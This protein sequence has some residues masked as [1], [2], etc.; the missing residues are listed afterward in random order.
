MEK[1][2]SYADFQ[3][4]KSVA[5]AC[6]PFMMKRDKIKRQIEALYVDYKREDDKIKVLEAGI[7][8]FIGFPVEQLV[9][10]V[11]ESGI[12]GKGQPIKTTKYIPTEIVSYDEKAK[13]Y[14]INIPDAEEPAV[15]PVDENTAEA[16]E[17][18]IF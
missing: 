4:V 8:Q 18:D 15:A 7:C 12:D 14:V 10:K 17:E 11:I 6:N 2:I 3:S 5:K 16:N 9:K 1:R 13:E